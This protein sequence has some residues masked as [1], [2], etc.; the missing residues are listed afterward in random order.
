MR[1]LIIESKENARYLIKAL[2]NGGFIV[3][4][5]SH[6]EKAVWRANYTHYDI[7]ISALHLPG[8]SGLEILKELRKRKNN[9]PFMIITLERALEA[10]IKSFQTGVDDYL[11]KPFSIH[12]LI[13]RM[14]AILRR[15]YKFKSPL[16]NDILKLHGIT[17][18]TN[19][20][21]VFKGK[22]ELF[23]RR[24][25]F[26]LLYYF[27]M[28]AGCVLPRAIILEKVWDM[29]ADPFTNTVD[30]HVKN[31]RKQMEDQEG[32]II[33][34]VYGRGYEFVKKSPQLN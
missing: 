18:D 21:R 14:K 20:F 24:K 12:E 28:N 25:E 9:V 4:W 31:L 3:D 30:V 23:L 6:W 33:R 16:R 32:R 15:T 5:E 8:K 7:L 34:T 11:V 17:L 10:K 13:A 27:M 19:S 22:K 29:H 2:N 26:D 1:A